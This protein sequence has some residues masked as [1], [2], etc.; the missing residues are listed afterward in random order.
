M[1]TSP[2]ALNNVTDGVCTLALQAPTGSTVYVGG[3][4]VTSATGWPV[5]GG[6]T[7]S[8]DLEATDVLYAVVASGTAVVPVLI[9]GA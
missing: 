6:T 9:G 1:G 7:A 2:V 5:A 8:F 4:T 3:S